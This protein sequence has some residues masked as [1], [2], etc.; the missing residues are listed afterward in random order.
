MIFNK[1]LKQNKDD[2]NF[3]KKEIVVNTCR[4]DIWSRPLHEDAF[5]LDE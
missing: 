5:K 4:N 2:F 3:K 1:F